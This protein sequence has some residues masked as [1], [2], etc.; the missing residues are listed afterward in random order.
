MPHAG[1]HECDTSLFCRRNDF[2]IADRTARFYCRN[3][4][5]VRRFD[6]PIRKR[7]ERIAGNDTAR[8]RQSVPLRMLNS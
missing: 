3:C 5:G 4:T 6:E 8:K 2:G 1:H 7:K